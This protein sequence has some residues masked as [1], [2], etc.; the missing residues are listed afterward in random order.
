[1]DVLIRLGLERGQGPSAVGLSQGGSCAQISRAGGRSVQGCCLCTSV[2]LC[3]YV[4][5]CGC[6]LVWCGKG[7]E[8]PKQQGGEARGVS[9]T[10]QS[11]G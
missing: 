5:V 9:K 6:S 1:M 4:C 3:A 11:P 8:L 2:P 7:K 10:G